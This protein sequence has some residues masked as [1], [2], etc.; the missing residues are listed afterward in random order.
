MSVLSQAKP[1]ALHVVGWL[2]ARSV[3]LPT[4]DAFASA[5][6]SEI[7]TGSYPFSS[8]ALIFFSMLQFSD[9]HLIESE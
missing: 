4:E 7:P 8:P 2:N 6:V 5:G 9:E 1:N 3:G